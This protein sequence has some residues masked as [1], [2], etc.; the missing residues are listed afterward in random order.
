ML[1]GGGD[2]NGNGNGNGGGGGGGNGDGGGDNFVLYGLLYAGVLA[3]AF[4]SRGIF[5]KEPAVPVAS[6]SCCRG[7]GKAGNKK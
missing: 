5:F 6:P 3:A 7:K 4:A 2:S 1:L